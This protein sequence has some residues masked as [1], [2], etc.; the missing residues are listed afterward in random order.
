MNT[1]D[2]TT[3]TANEFPCTV[4]VR[5]HTFM[6]D[7]DAV[8]GGS[9]SAPSA[10]DY[11]DSALA[12]CKALTAIWYAKRK[13]I[14]LERVAAHV[15]RDDSEERK[16]VYKLR[17]R[18]ELIGAAMTPEQHADVQR[19]IGGCPIHKLMATTDVQIETVA[20]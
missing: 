20:P 12:A 9:D 13:H 8:T 6:T 15:E 18:V 5:T 1:I 2:V 4:R 7:V 16:G 17:V 3:N 14:P 10:H 19:A 11:F